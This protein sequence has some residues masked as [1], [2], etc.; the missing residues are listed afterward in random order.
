MDSTQHFDDNRTEILEKGV[1]NKIL[2]QLNKLK[3]NSTEESR[4]R[5]I[6][7]LIQNAK[8]VASKNGNVNIHIL[9]DKANKEICFQHNGDLFTDK[10]ILYLIEQ[11]SSKEQNN[12]DDGATGK[13]GTGFLTTHLLSEKAE[14]SGILMDEK[15]GL[16]KSFSLD[17][18]RSGY[19][20][21]EIINANHLSNNQLK[22]NLVAIDQDQFN[23]NAFN[24][25]FKYSL[26]INGVEVAEAGLKDFF[27]AIA[28]VF[29]FVPQLSSISVNNDK[30]FF[31]RV[32]KSEKGN[33]ICQTDIQ[34]FIDGNKT[35]RHII[36]I[37]QDDIDIALEI[38]GSNQPKIMK[39]HI[40][41]PKLF[42][43]FPLVGTSDFPIPFLVNSH[44]FNPTEPR[45]GIFLKSNEHPDAIEN[46]DVL[47]KAIKLYGELLEVISK[48]N[49]EQ[50]YNIT[51]VSSI[52]IKSWVPDIWLENSIISNV[53]DSILDA[54]IF[55]TYLGERCA[56]RDWFKSPQIFIINDSDEKVRENIWQ[57]IR[58]YMPEN[59]T[60]QAEIHMWYHSLWKECRNYS[61]KNLVSWVEDKK[62]ISKLYESSSS[63]FDF[64][65]WINN[66]YVMIQNNHR[67]FSNILDENL[68]VFP[69]QLGEF[70]SIN[71]LFV[72]EVSDDIYKDILE[73]AEEGCRHKL[74]DSGIVIKYKMKRYGNTEIFKEIYES[75]GDELSVELDVYKKIGKLYKEDN[76]LDEEQSELLSILEDLDELSASELIS[77]KEIPNDLYD[78]AKKELFRYVV[79]KVSECKSLET[80]DQEI[81]N[82]SKEWIVK[83][84][85]SL[86]KYNHD[87][88]LELKRHPIL[89]N[90]HGRFLPKEEL[91]LDNGEIDSILKD[92]ASEEG[93]DI[94]SELLLTEIY[95]DLPQ[96]RTR[97][98]EDIAQSVIS[99]VKRCQTIKV[100]DDQ[101]KA[102]F[103][104]LFLW[105]TDNEE[106]ARKYFDEL[107]TNKHW[108][109]DDEEIAKNIRKAE[110]YD[111]IL[112]EYKV[113]SKEELETILRDYHKEETLEITEELLVQ[114]G[115]FDEDDLE[116]AA[117]NN[118]FGDHFKHD[119]EHDNSE[120]YQYAMKL[121]KRATNRIFEYLAS[122]DEYDVNEPI[123]IDKTVYIIRKHDKE[124]YL[125]IRPSDYDKV[126][127]YYNTEYDVLDFEKDWELWVEDANRSP[128][129][130]TFGKM[131]KLTGI[132][133]IPLRRVVY[134]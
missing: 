114:A 45:D 10:S 134:R 33:G 54:K 61:L 31:S 11:V 72:D 109:Y 34:Q 113:R 52:P 117:N 47:I 44:R 38:D 87:N 57:L 108:L 103:K 105:I 99:Y 4:R 48:Q 66:F 84:I 59:I 101:V 126:I 76:A 133:K 93:N 74:L 43:D 19:T 95:L 42:C 14:V 2:E 91:F 102:N 131:L 17:L 29:V 21:R 107:Y 121:Q 35:I 70:C 9:Y 67:L 130:I 39:Y 79:H 64:Y 20:S 82:S 75:I 60:K 122:C 97:G 28:Y 63:D 118:V 18:D 24:T 116:K 27:H 124:I 128:E 111:S 81:T 49:W 106:N 6:W 83:L 92:I 40:S 55:D 96:S 80:L 7:E 89:P 58:W 120:K 46:K 90:Q 73:D 32:N 68:K 25:S 123:Q 115:I 5:W 100:L 26:D 13:F 16:L 53:K 37:S 51:K 85:N 36:S 132:N 78:K 56:F 69:N 22:Q 112:N 50:V 12:C 23:S 119:I 77:V 3:M 62:N 71:E 41:V 1:A 86:N 15:D 125:I 110:E 8:D 30:W 129:R 88:L 127:L 65:S 98:I 104:M 94:R